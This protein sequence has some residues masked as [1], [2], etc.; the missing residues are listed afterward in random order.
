MFF[1]SKEESDQS[2]VSKQ[3]PTT[4]KSPRTRSERKAT[5]DPNLSSSTTSERNLAEELYKIRKALTSY[6]IRLESQNVRINELSQLMKDNFSDLKTETN[7]CSKS[8]A[9]VQKQQQEAKPHQQQ[10]A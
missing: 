7:A 5:V 9:E 1:Y 3:Q 4:A 10:S 2:T 6:N 8:Q